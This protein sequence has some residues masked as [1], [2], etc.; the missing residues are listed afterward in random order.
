MLKVWVTKNEKG[1]V[2]VWS[3]NPKLV[4]G[5]KEPSW[6]NMI[7][8]FYEADAFG[9]IFGFTPRKGSCKQMELSLKEIE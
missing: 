5:G 6:D 7:L 8:G 4:L 9:D 1:L 2:A 3:V